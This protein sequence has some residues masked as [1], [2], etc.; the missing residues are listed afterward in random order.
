MWSEASMEIFSISVD[1]LTTENVSTFS[2]ATAG[3]AKHVVI[4]ENIKITAIITF[5][6]RNICIFSHPFLVLRKAQKVDETDAPNATIK[7]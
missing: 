6:L 1:T 3:I 2:V 7:F 5:E 4:R